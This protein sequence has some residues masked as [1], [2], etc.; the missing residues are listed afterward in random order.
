M[1]AR[2][3]RPVARGRWKPDRLEDFSFG[4]F[5]AEL[6]EAESPSRGRHVAKRRQMH[7][8]LRTWTAHAQEM[9]RQAFP[10]DGASPLAPARAPWIYRIDLRGPDRRGAT[11]YE[12]SAW[13][14]QLVSSDGRV[15]E[16]R[17]PTNRADRPRTRAEISI[18][19]LV[20]AE[21][22]PGPLPEHVRVVQ[23][24]LSDGRCRPLF[25]GDR[26]AA[27]R[28]FA[29][30]GK[31][32]LEN[33]VDSIEYR[34]GAACAK[35]AFISVCPALP[36]AS[37][38]LGVEDRERPRRSWS[39]TNGRS[40]RVCPARDHLRRLNLP[41]ECSM[42]HSPAADRGRAVHG[43]L[44]RRHASASQR[45]CSLDIPSDWVGPEYTLPDQEQELGKRLLRHHVTVCPLR[46]ARKGA[47]RIEP[48]LTFHDTAS[49]VIVITQP[50][51]LY[52]DGDSWVWREVK[53][54]TGERRWGSDVLDGSPQLA[55]A[56]VLLGRGDLGGSRTRSRVELEI[57][58]PGGVDLEVI[59]PFTP[60]VR[61][62]AQNVLVEH[63]RAWHS[64]TAASPR[65]DVKNCARCEVARWCTACATG[66]DA[67]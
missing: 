32:E 27:R 55:L 17:L 31:G 61:E 7:D 14:R 9:Y 49:D 38:L 56:V 33:A 34:P 13:G 28:L 47:V 62:T 42:E 54:R 5:M 12:I 51:L 35:C 30:H 44:A 39:P 58:R 22:R 25:E 15:R 57:L 50:D 63:V 16:L 45:R 46:H 41:T 20:A 21:G 19:A 40:Y 53:T 8:G 24:G 1:K 23:V 59:D 64:D 18:A 6:D 11:R 52:Q 66:G 43:F 10:A 26:E 65:P 37:G 60:S 29:E 2:C 36:R 3:L 67:G 48:S 4:P